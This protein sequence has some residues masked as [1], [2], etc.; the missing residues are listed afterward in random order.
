[1]SGLQG[2]QT[3]SAR[4]SVLVHPTGVSRKSVEAREHWRATIEATVD[5]R[6]GDVGRAL[7]GPERRALDRL[8]PDGHARFWGTWR[9]HGAQMRSL[10]A[11][12]IAVFTAEGRIRGLGRVGLV[13]ENPALGDAL[14]RHPPREGSYLHVYTVDP[15]ITADEPLTGLRA[16]GVTWFQTPLYFDDDRAAR[17]LDT[18][19]AQ[20]GP[21]LT[22]VTA[23]ESAVLAAID[24]DAADEALA[25][26][27]TWVREIPIEVATTGD[28]PVSARAASTMRRGESLLVHDFV[29]HLPPGTKVR[30]LVTAVGTTDIDIWRDAQHELVEAKSSAHRTYVRQALAQLLDYASAPGIE[31][32]DVLTALFPRRPDDSAVALLHRYGIDCVHR[33]EDGE[34][35]RAEAPRTNTDVVRRLWRRSNDRGEPVSGTPRR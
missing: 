26:E 11:G 28:V 29:A 14:W 13:T 20:I 9:K 17:I 19:A 18:Y 16:A 12:D 27:L 10:S 2:P 22:E 23:V 31:A 32:P 35:R 6:S 7:T 33:G 5:F 8:H 21:L 4:P 1:M 30:R 15:F 24:Y 25:A 34:Y 3:T